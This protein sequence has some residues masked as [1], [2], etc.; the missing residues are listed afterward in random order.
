MAYTAANSTRYRR[1]PTAAITAWAIF[2]VLLVLS[3]VAYV[4]KL[5]MV[6]QA[7]TI[8]DAYSI[9]GRIE[10]ANVQLS[11]NGREAGVVTNS[12]RISQKLELMFEGTPHDGMLDEILDML[13][14]YGVTATFFLSGQ[15]VEKNP[16]AA[17]R[18][19]EQGHTL[20]NYSYTAKEHMENLPQAAMIEE[21][22]YA[23]AAMYRA[24][25]VNPTVLRCNATAYTPALL[26]AAYACGL[27]N[28]YDTAYTVG[29]NSFDS[30][31]AVSSFS[32]A[33]ARGSMVSI[34]L[35]GAAVKPNIP[36][37][38][39]PETLAAMD[40]QETA[41]P[42]AAAVAVDMEALGER[43]RV[44]LI[45]EWFL[46]A[47]NDTEDS[48]QAIALRKKNNGALAEKIPYIHTTQR[49][50]GY[51]FTGVGEAQELNYLLSTLHELQIRA[52]FFVTLEEA[53]N[54]GSRIEQILEQGHALGIA[55]PAAAGG[56]FN[57]ACSQINNCRRYL[58]ERFGYN[59]AGVVKQVAGDV[60]NTLLEAVSATG[61]QIVA[62]SIS[63]VQAVVQEATDVTGAADKM[64]EMFVTAFRRGELINFAMN[65]YTQSTTL[66]GDL[67][68]FLHENYSIY[69]GVPVGEMLNN[70]EKCYTFPVPDENML[71]EAAGRIEAGHIA[72]MDDDAF[73]EYMQTHYLGTDYTCNTKTLPGFSKSQVEKLNV[74]GRIHNGNN[75]IFFTFD[76][77]GDDRT[78][79]PLL[80]VLEKHNAPATFCIRT[81][82]I[83]ANPNLMRAIAEGGHHVC[84]HTNTHYALAEDDDG[85][86]VFTELS[87]ADMEKF[88]EDI[89]TSYETLL[90]IVGDIKTGNK[91]ALQPIFRP[92]T[93]AI[94]KRGA[95]A[96]YDAGFSY[97][98]SGDY[99]THDYAAS[100]PQQLYK[101]LKSNIK[102][103]SVVIMH[104]S[105]TAVHT[106]EAVDLFLTD[107]AKR[108]EGKRFVPSLIADYLNGTYLTER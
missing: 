78:I 4:C 107:N 63:A 81:N 20:G 23:S 24:T 67:V 93:L 36:A 79:T 58:K 16:E 64:A 75:A 10:R 22:C 76:D 71:P 52:T 66:L 5:K 55:V 17:K 7:V 2:G 59:D 65:Y 45:T 73:F 41:S 56:D 21:F 97:I 83:S 51:L 35:S 106:A 62:H 94:S 31:E 72:H 102:S 70:T 3:I 44:L 38:P 37:T 101:E 84:S 32:N 105:P 48:P 18:I 39:A 96:V 80:D 68:R 98:V 82:F 8:Q 69:E 50:I 30:Y 47:L 15:E 99:S 54:A 34:R 103:G 12:G 108:S 42:A 104:I 25:G 26:Q 28:I 33:R 92:P 6:D 19:I 9:E 53:Q 95:W 11:K 74:E 29:Y 60:S 87:E 88:Q 100:S 13:D 57:A 1:R 46:R 49:A 43:E 61:C 27:D 77:W 90:S 40:I 14:Y 91:A 89:I 85:D 86:G